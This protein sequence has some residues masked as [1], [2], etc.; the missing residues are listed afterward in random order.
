MLDELLLCVKRR[1]RTFLKDLIVLKS[2]VDT[3]SEI[4]KLK[5]YTI[6]LYA[7]PFIIPITKLNDA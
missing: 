1:T 3:D 7:A 4:D 6:L 5:K 2:I